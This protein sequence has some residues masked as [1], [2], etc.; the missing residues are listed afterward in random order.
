MEVAFRRSGELWRSAIIDPCHP[1]I[2]RGFRWARRVS[3]Q[4]PICFNPL[5]PLNRQ[6]NKSANAKLDLDQYV[7]KKV[8][9]QLVA[10]LSDCRPSEKTGNHHPATLWVIFDGSTVHGLLIP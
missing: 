5:A 6:S 4:R 1:Q 9:R 3:V 8:P 7:P 10:M 2:R